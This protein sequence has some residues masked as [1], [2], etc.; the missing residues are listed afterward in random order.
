[1]NICGGTLFCLPQE[2]RYKYIKKTPIKD[3]DSQTEWKKQDPTVCCLQEAHTEE[4]NEREEK[5]ILC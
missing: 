2:V 1:M 4:E 5:D 3:R